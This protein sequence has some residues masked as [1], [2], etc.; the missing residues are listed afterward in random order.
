MIRDWRRGMLTTSGS[1]IEGRTDVDGQILRLSGFASE[2]VA[3]IE[4]SNPQ[5]L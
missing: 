3:R 4:R 1:Y 5:S 2:E